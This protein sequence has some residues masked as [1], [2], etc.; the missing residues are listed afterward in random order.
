MAFNT[1]QQTKF[2]YVVSKLNQHQAVDVEDIITTPPQQEPYDRLKAE[3]LRR[4]SNSH[5]QRRRQ[6]HSHEEMGDREV[7]SLAKDV[8]NDFLRNIW[9]SQLPPHVQAIISG[10]TE[11]SLVSASNLADRIC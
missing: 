10:Q 6:L 9:D 3:L 8:P 11:G 5:D 2:G 4:F 1:L 7:S